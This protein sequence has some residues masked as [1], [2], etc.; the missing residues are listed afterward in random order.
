[1]CAAPQRTPAH[2]WQS[3]LLTYA[4]VWV[5]F[6]VGTIRIP[7]CLNP[8]RAFTQGKEQMADQD[9]KKQQSQQGG[10]GGQQQG[11]GQGGQGKD[12]QNQQPNQKPGQ[13]GQQGGQS[14]QQNPQK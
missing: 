3:Q 4:S 10:Q 14:G 5:G 7:G 9:D 6:S 1:M 8:G 11:G 13:G 2:P 12:Q